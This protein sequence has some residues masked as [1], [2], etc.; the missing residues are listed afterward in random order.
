MYYGFIWDNKLVKSYYE[1][2][3]KISCVNYIITLNRILSKKSYKQQIEA[4]I[5]QFRDGY[6]SIDYNFSGDVYNTNIDIDKSNIDDIVKAIKK[7][8]SIKEFQINLIEEC[9]EY[10]SV[11]IEENEEIRNNNTVF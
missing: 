7:E 11:N 6:N 10:F 5:E 4:Y 2:Y 1:N 9:Q 8:I 3:D